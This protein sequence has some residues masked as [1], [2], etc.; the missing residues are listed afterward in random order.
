VVWGPDPAAIARLG[1]TV[2]VRV[3]LADQ[4]PYAGGGG[5]GCLVIGS[6]R[7]GDPAAWGTRVWAWSTDVRTILASSTGPAVTMVALTRRRP[8]LTRAEFAAHWTDRHA[9]LALRHHVGLA[10][11]RQHVVVDALT[12]GAEVVDGIAL[13]GFASH[14]DFATRFYDSEAGKR[15]IRDDVRHFL[16]PPGGETTLVGPPGAGGADGV[17]GG[18]G[19]EG[20]EGVEGAEGVEGGEG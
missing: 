10:D 3:A 13:L 2:M 1:G 19:G 14:A 8:D 6:G 17:E 4:G 20:V 5:F 12:P 7:P 18:E 11:Y 9:P 15:A 16:G